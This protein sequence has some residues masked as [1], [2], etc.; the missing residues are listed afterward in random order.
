MNAVAAARDLL[1]MA[2]ELVGIDFSTQH[3]FDKYM[4]DHPDADRSNHRVVKKDKPS[5]KPESKPVKQTKPEESAE[6]EEHHNKHLTGEAFHSKKGWRTRDGK[7]LPKHVASRVIP[8][9]W[10]E[11]RFDPD[12]NAELVVQGYDA[13]GRLQSKYS[14]S[15]IVR[16]AAV[17]FA[18]IGELLKKADEIAN[19][20]EAALKSGKN[21]ESAACLRLIMKT[22]IRPGSDTDTKAEKR[23][24]GATTLQG[25]HV[26]G[27]KG[28]VHLVFT[29][30]KGVDLDIKV[31]DP[32]IEE[33]LLSR[34]EKVG[35]SGK[36]F[37]TTDKA[38]LGY[39]H[40][41]DGGMFKTKDM[42]TM[43]GTATALV[44]V[45][46]IPPPMTAEEYVKNV[47]AVAE[48]VAKKLGN[49]PVVALQ[50]YISPTVFTGWR[51]VG[52]KFKMKA[53]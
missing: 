8:P 18:R 25:R 22:G 29:G 9:A 33:D 32:S 49:T 35:R 47:K 43:V 11:V 23:A 52:W 53:A 15:H 10:K 14:D 1:V 24:Y 12:P 34:A 7:E 6:S 36:L 20:N 46:K 41:L 37:D 42:R 44:E 40:T 48:A 45:S 50:S 51:Q 16:Q 4:K 30:K 31:D 2:K 39:T 21:K 3:E 17:K 27:T 19:E 26:V 28:D 13:K 38:L 5:S